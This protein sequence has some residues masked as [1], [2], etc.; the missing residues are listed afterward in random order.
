M[1]WQLVLESISETQGERMSLI[2][3][4]P[5]ATLKDPCVLVSHRAAGIKLERSPSRMAIAV[6]SLKR[7]ASA[8]SLSPETL[9]NI[10]V[11]AKEHIETVE[12]LERMYHRDVRILTDRINELSGDLQSATEDNSRLKRA[13]T[14]IKGSLDD[15]RRDFVKVK[16]EVQNQHKRNYDLHQEV[17]DS[18]THREELQEVNRVV[19]RRVRD[20][21][22]ILARLC[23]KNG[24][25]INEIIRS[26]NRPQ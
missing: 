12:C 16:E 24:L 11:T 19:L 10:S 3:S 14:A 20:Y 8:P 5:K 26:R 23:Q 25:D 9:P 15:M 1:G 4:E 22:E 17:L 13:L 2:A 18:S 7:R 6:L 21:K